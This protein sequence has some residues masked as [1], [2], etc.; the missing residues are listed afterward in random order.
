M[1]M[2]VLEKHIKVHK[3]DSELESF[4]EYMREVRVKLLEDWRKRKD[5]SG[6]RVVSQPAQG[7][8]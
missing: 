2:V 7:D 5:G 8:T 4:V 3:E 6:Q 1:E